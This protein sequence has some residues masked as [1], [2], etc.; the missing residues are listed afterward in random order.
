MIKTLILLLSIFI[1]SCQDKRLVEDN[2]I[3]IQKCDYSIISQIKFPDDIEDLE[4]KN[5]RCLDKVIIEGKNK[6][7]ANKFKVLFSDQNYLLAEY[8]SK[9]RLLKD[10][11]NNTWF[12][13]KAPEPNNFKGMGYGLDGIYIL[14]N[15]LN[16]IF[17][18]HSGEISK[19]RIDDK[20]K[21][22]YTIRVKLNKKINLK[23]SIEKMSY[24]ELVIIFQELKKGNY[25]E[26]GKEKEHFF[27]EEG[28][29]L[30]T[31]NVIM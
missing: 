19:Y 28:V 31:E 13:I 23:E 2:N 20:L 22:N 10:N 4:Q 9:T 12:L 8:D 1:V 29:P 11:K 5:Y 24:N 6:K 14:D 18:I 3:G 30:W 26:I 25:T 7:V 17:S 27:Y 15:D 21:K 16:P